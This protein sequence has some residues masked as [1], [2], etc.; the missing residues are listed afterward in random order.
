MDEL[1]S[2]LR[3][4]SIEQSLRSHETRVQLS[5]SKI[6]HATQRPTGYRSW[7]QYNDVITVATIIDDRLI[8]MT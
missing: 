3:A 5:S 1:T 4:T 7:R 8:G 6:E 2:V